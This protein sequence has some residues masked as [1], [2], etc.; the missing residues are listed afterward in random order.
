ML[1]KLRQRKADNEHLGIKGDVLF[2]KVPTITKKGNTRSE[3]LEQTT[4]THSPKYALLPSTHLYI[5]ILQDKIFPSD[6]YSQRMF[7][8]FILLIYFLQ[9]VRFCSY[10]IYNI[11]D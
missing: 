8:I 10:K 11:T 3:E 7:L 4:H 2:T 6:H 1:I 5:K 9:G